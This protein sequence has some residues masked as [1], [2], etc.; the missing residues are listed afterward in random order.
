MDYQGEAGI[1]MYLRRSEVTPDSKPG[2]RGH[3]YTEVDVGP[4]AT[5]YK[6]QISSFTQ[7]TGIVGTNCKTNCDVDQ[8][9]DAEHITYTT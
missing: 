6:L 5:K 2:V 4:L 1:Q 7:I 9:M 3:F 8:K